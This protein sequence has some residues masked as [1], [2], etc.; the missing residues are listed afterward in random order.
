M[1]ENKTQRTT[2]SVA[3]FLGAIADPHR[4][5]D[6]K[7]LAALFRK[8]TGETPAMWGSSI[9]GYGQTTYQGRSGRTVDWFPVGF[10]PRKAALV[11]Y[12]MGGLKAH[13]GLLTELGPHKVG[14]GCLYLRRLEEIDTKV[15]TRLIKLSDK[16]NRRV[17]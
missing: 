13:A 7:A 15:L 6:A 17:T 11:V 3:A 10:S 4:R 12:L 1:A 2:S 16:G 8:A 14:G 9:V 5:R